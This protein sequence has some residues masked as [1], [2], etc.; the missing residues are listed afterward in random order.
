MIPSKVIAQIQVFWDENSE[1]FQSRRQSSRGSSFISRS[2][3]CELS[4]Q[5]L[6]LD[7]I[8]KSSVHN[9]KNSEKVGPRAKS[10]AAKINFLNQ[11]NSDDVIENMEMIGLVMDSPSYDEVSLNG[12]LYAENVKDV[13]I[14][15][16]DIVGFSK[17]SMELSPL[18][19]MNMLEALFSRFDALCEKHSVEKLET[20][21]ELLEL[22][23]PL[24][25]SCSYQLI[26]TLYRR[27]IYMY[28][29]FI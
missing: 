29:Q 9:E 20:I 6:D 11:I 28:N 12:A 10:V 25:H 2:S 8:E 3:S 17:M 19:V 23:F 7:S 13:V 16:L 22:A 18:K 15:F 5:D 27:R 24:C 14:I 1:E 4:G 26:V 21:G